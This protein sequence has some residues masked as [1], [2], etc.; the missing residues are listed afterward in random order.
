MW[1]TYT[2]WFQKRCNQ[3][4]SPKGIRY[5]DSQSE[6]D[7]RMATKQSEVEDVVNL[8]KISIAQNVFKIDLS[9]KINK[10]RLV[11]ILARFLVLHLK[12]TIFLKSLTNKEN[13]WADSNMRSKHFDQVLKLLLTARR[14]CYDKCTEI[15]RL[16]CIFSSIRLHQ[17]I[18]S[19]G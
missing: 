19:A 4:N 1:Y 5:E 8:A 9:Q 11:W 10:T 13:V 16:S 18:D 7:Q 6:V 14:V 15:K 17:F 3:R 12:S 2:Q